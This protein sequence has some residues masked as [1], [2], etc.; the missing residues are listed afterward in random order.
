MKAWDPSLGLLAK[1]WALRVPLL[2]VRSIGP[3]LPP[4]YSTHIF[5]GVPSTKL[6]PRSPIVTKL[7]AN[8]QQRLLD[9]G[10]I[11]LSM[12]KSQEGDPQ[13]SPGNPRRLRVTNDPLN[14]GVPPRSTRVPGECLKYS[15]SH[16][17]MIVKQ[18][19]VSVTLQSTAFIATQGV[20]W[21]YFGN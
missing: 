6:T 21:Q 20:C 14:A 17:L 12:R 5:P 1:T 4:G 11:K 16:H 2:L 9:R 19:A 7:Y 13:R 18:R 8:A 3:K 10:Q 15:N